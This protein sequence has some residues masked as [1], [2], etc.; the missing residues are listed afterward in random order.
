[1]ADGAWLIFQQVRGF[2][3][4]LVHEGFVMHQSEAATHDPCGSNCLN[5]PSISAILYRLAAWHLV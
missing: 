5:P 3:K 1:M 2:W 4:V